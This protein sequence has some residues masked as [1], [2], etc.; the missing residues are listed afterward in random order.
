MY[1]YQ[2]YEYRT[3]T[4]SGYVAQEQSDGTVKVSHQNTL[5]GEE[6]NTLG[7]QGWEL[8]WVGNIKIRET[9]E[10]GP[11][12]LYNR[13]D[14]ACHEKYGLPYSFVYPQEASWYGGGF[15]S[16]TEVI[17]GFHYI[18]R[19]M[20]PTARTRSHRSRRAQTAVGR[21]YLTLVK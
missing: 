18:F 20:K 12:E 3:I 15:A 14:K 5:T 16:S 10:A 6:L 7:Q 1:G 2:I 11:Y 13:L 17:E 8:F 19:R 9:R 4:R 21:D